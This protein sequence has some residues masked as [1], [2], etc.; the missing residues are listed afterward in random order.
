[1]K[2]LQAETIDSE[3]KSNLEQNIADLK[4]GELNIIHNNFFK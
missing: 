4:Y 2:I 1:M 3:E